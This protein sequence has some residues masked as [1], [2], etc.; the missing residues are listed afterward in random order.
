M[1]NLIFILSH[2]FHIKLREPCLYDFVKKTFSVG[3]FSDIY[4]LL[5]FKFGMMIETTKL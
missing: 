1:I 4:R 3:L 2:P 5:S